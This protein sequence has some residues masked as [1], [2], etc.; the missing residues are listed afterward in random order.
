MDKA[1]RIGVIGFDGVVAPYGDL[2]GFARAIYAGEP[3]D[4]GVLDST[5]GAGGRQRA[6]GIARLVHDLVGR[7]LGEDVVARARW[8]LIA[9]TDVGNAPPL[10]QPL[11]PQGWSRTSSVDDLSEALATSRGWL[12]DGVVDVVVMVGVDACCTGVL[13]FAP[14]SAVDDEDLDKVAA[15]LG[16]IRGV[17]EGVGAFHNLP[18]GVVDYLESDRVPVDGD[19]AQAWGATEGDQSPVCAVSTL[20]LSS[21]VSAPLTALFKVFI[22]LQRRFLPAM[23]GWATVEGPAVAEAGPFY[24]EAA[25]RT[26]F[27]RPGLV[28]RAAL[29]WHYQGQGRNVTWEEPV[30]HRSTY[31]DVRART[32]GATAYLYPIAGESRAA[33]LDGLDKLAAQLEA[34]VSLTEAGRDLYAA[35]RAVP[36]ASYALALVGRHRDDLLKE[37]AYA[38]DGVKRA[39]T[40][41]RDWQTPRGSAFSPQP[42]GRDGVAFVYPGAFNAYVGLGRDLFQHVPGLHEHFV[43][44]ISDLDRGM[45]TS[46]LYPRSRRPLKGED[47]RAADALLRRDPASMIEAGMIFSIAYTSILCDLCKVQPHYALG[48][49]LGEASMLWGLGV[50]E[51]GDTGSAKLHSSRLFSSRIFGPKMAV[52]EHWD[53][54]SGDDDFWSIHLLKAAVDDVRRQVEQE[55]HVYLTIVNLVDE[56]VIAGSR[57][58][59]ERV[60]AALDCHALPVPSG[61][62]IH[63]EAMRSEYE[64]FRDLYSDP[65]VRQPDVAFYSAADYEPVHVERDTLADALARMCCQPVD[66]VRLVERAYTDGARLFVE[67]GPMGTCTR[68]IQRILRG[69][70]HTAVAINGSGVSDFAG[71]LTV[72]ARLIAHRVPLDLDAFFAED[73]LVSPRLRL[74]LPVA[75]PPATVRRDVSPD[76]PW[77]PEVDRSPVL[78]G[79]VAGAGVSHRPARSA[80]GGL[81]EPPAGIAA[82]GTPDDALLAY[83]RYMLP[84]RER[85]VAAHET[86]LHTRRAAQAEIRTLIEM[87]I[88]AS[89]QLL[90]APENTAEPTLLP[91]AAAS[92]SLTP[93]PRFDEDQLRAFALGDPVRCFGPAFAVYRGRRLPRIPNGP[94]LFLSRV[95]EVHGEPGVF[96]DESYLISAY[97]VPVD[98]W[99]YDGPR[100]SGLPPYAVLMEMALQ[101]CGFLSAYLG[102]S[103]LVPDA[104]FYFRNLDGRGKVLADED[105]RGK[106][107]RD[108]VRLVSSTRGQG[109]I[110]QTFTYVLSCEGVPFYEGWASFGYFAGEAL[111]RQVGLD[112]GA[113]VLPWH[114]EHS[115]ALQPLSLPVWDAPDRLRLVEELRT[116]PQGGRYNAGYLYGRV[117]ISPADWFF[118]AHFYQDPVM[119]GSLGVEAALQALRAYGA[120][121]YPHLRAAP[122]GHVPGQ[123]AEWKYRGQVTRE[124]REIALE[125]HLSRV[126][127]GAEGVTLV[128]DAYIWKDDLRIYAVLGLALRLEASS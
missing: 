39:F 1:G 63:N 122:G 76:M 27:A 118:R 45:A 90:G 125:V 105:L 110:I 50:W 78:A 33:I 88:A 5:Q 94:L 80:A 123:T 40:K 81:Q 14:V 98:A 93:P 73:A 35:Y 38:R 23:P 55:P 2:E 115:I 29:R 9:Y 53:H 89:Q 51:D 59:C 83:E 117:P 36:N 46:L 47:L 100:Y 28:R 74:R 124:D 119:P 111:A 84:H 91:S 10:P 4:P 65:V 95:A 8:G 82:G 3:L 126:V 106:F 109:A 56:V 67:L 128:A 15:V 49:S 104:D 64:I 24:G 48:Y 72:V 25:S 16:A 20:A 60:I 77:E 22:A 75:E 102:S 31:P 96:G 11:A 108:E 37:I 85:A 101:P 71:V 13:L 68:W 86:F 103:L 26:W 114:L 97:D 18:D 112:K 42:L 7:T 30:P 61:V 92:Q 70:P 34:G 69:R 44:L 116:A 41:G 19:L 6:G 113:R 54:R 99:F 87:Q 43:N 21:S 107:V 52:R 57:E 32:G 17:A 127:E 66:F 79:A 120:R 58:G 121:A 12:L 62:V